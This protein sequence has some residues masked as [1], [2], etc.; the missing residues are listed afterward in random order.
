V[1]LFVAGTDGG[2]GKTTIA[3]A[4]VRRLRAIGKDAIGMKPI[5]TGCPYGPDQDLVGP[6]GETLH[7]A[8]HRSAPPLVVS[9]YRLPSRADPAEALE[10]AGIELELDDLVH[11]VE[12]A[13][14]FSEVLVVESTGGALAPLVHDG[15][16]LDLAERLGASVIVVAPD[17]LGSASAV[18]LILEALRRRAL[19]IAGVLLTRLHDGAHPETGTERL[20]RERGGAQVFPIV[21][22]I[23]GDEKARILGVEAHLA[24]HRI[25]EALLEAGGR[26]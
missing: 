7:V 6:D 21:P 15:L 19:N 13:Q 26:P 23:E 8:A 17:A 22:F 2:V 4:L 16:G 18:I 14:R 5:E 11:A 10:R 20:V 1:I 9:P 25:A 12:A 24:A 3:A